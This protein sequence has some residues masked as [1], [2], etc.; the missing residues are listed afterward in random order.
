MGVFANGLEIS[1]KAVQAKTIA[2]FPDTCFT[3]PQ[4]PATPPG[5]P[6]PYPSFGMA[7]D[8]EKGT[9]SVLIGGKTV[10]IKNKSDESRTS[11]TE[12]GCAPKKGLITSKNTGKKYF[13]KWSLNVKFEGEPVIR[14][15]DLATH[16]HSSPIGNTVTWLEVALAWPPTNPDGT[17]CI[18][19]KYGQKQPD[20][21][22]QGK[23]GEYQFHHIIPDRCFRCDRIEVELDG[24]LRE[25][26]VRMGQTKA[27]NPYPSRNGGIC[28]CLPTTA[29]VPSKSTPGTYSVH[30]DLDDKLTKMGKSNTPPGLAPLKKVRGQCFASLGKLVKEGKISRDCYRLAVEMVMEATKDIEDSQIRGEKNLKNLDPKSRKAMCSQ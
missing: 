21:A 29:H 11:G 15:T 18:V 24:E 10:N 8:T 4:T 26:D 13:H 14:F 19:G 27:E 1:G 12:A 9:G 17:E 2:A 6:V 16:N 30:G 20:C 3:P 25:R 7:S 5:V 23:P 28:I 22:K